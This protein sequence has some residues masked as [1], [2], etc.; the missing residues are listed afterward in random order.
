M[1]RTIPGMIEVEG[2]E[3]FYIETVA[4]DGFD[5]ILD[6]ALAGS[7]DLP[8]PNSGGVIEEKVRILLDGNTSLL[9]IS[10]KGDLAG[11]KAKLV[12]FCNTK[13][14]KWGTVSRQKVELSDGRELDLGKCNVVFEG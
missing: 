4:G 2:R 9:G 3:F 1:N 10:Y 13:H 5:E 14:R 11:W 8:L 7:P 6:E 12:A